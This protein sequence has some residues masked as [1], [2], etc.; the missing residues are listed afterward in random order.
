MKRNW[1]ETQ[2]NFWRGNTFTFEKEEPIEVYEEN[3]ILVKRY[4]AHAAAGVGIRSD[5]RS[6]ARES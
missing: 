4:R 1:T 5:V 2:R 3:G 6:K